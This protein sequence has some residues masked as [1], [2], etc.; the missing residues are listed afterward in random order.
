MAETRGFA[1]QIK[2][3][4]LA[5][6]AFSLANMLAIRCISGTARTADYLGPVVAM[7]TGSG[8]VHGSIFG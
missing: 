2:P 1:K 8:A 5:G 3:L 6:R 7:A 4:L